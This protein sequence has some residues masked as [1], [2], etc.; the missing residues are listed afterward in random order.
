MFLVKHGFRIIGRNYLRKWGEI[1]VICKKEGKIHFIEVKAGETQENVPRETE[2]NV[3]RGTFYRPEEHVTHE[4]LERLS[5][6]IQ[7]YI[8]EQG[9]PRETKFQLDVL[10]IDLNLKDKTAK[11]RF[12][13]NVL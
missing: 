11:T 12:I 2:N 7:T 6:V 9:V 3:S 10:A 5:R 1:D 8:S 4:K 13:E